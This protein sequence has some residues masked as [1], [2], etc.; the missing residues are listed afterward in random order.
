MG[1]E[2]ELGWEGW[3]VLYLMTLTSTISPRVNYEK[4]I[5]IEFSW[6]SLFMNYSLFLIFYWNLGSTIPPLLSFKQTDSLYFICWRVYTTYIKCS[7]LFKETHVF[8]TK[9][10][11]LTS[12][13]I[14]RLV[15]IFRNETCL[16]ESEAPTLRVADRGF[17]Q[18][19]R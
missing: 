14:A 3:V 18:T 8:L 12:T 11:Q 9:W 17:S 6:K 7:F 16:S 13:K 15:H 19:K 10:P 5:K 4:K 2:I 1:C